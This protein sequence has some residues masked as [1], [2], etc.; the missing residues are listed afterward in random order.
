MGRVEMKA[1]SQTRTTLLTRLWRTWACTALLLW[2]GWAAAQGF[3]LRDD[4]GVVHHFEQPAQRVVSLLPSLTEV[5][6]AL[7]A[8]DRL[9]GVDRFSDWPAAVAQL[10]RLGGIDDAQI[11][12]IATLKPD[13]VLAST[14]A[15][16]ID[17]LES[18]GFKV[19]RLKSDTHADV[20]RTLILVAQLLG[21]PQRGVQV[22]DRI[23][24]Q[25]A[26]A[27]QQV[28]PTLRG[29]S[30]YFEIGG[31]PF[32]AGS[33]SFIGQTLLRLG[34]HNIVPPELGP[35]PKLNPE[36]VVRARPQIVM[37]ASREQTLMASRPGW[38]NLPA[39]QQGQQC[40]FASAEYDLLIRP[41][42][43]LGEAAALLARCL[44]RIESR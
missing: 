40:G 14:S 35:F 36:F 6:A 7:G 44:Q 27:A 25:L 41:G 12:A 23:Q 26:Q 30:V 8:A 31:G 5:V 9:V 39:I 3:S 38:Q 10:P 24:G 19:L 15:R 11:E 1:V 20:Q 28:P 17:R 2:A 32:A 42:P 34:L 29:Q 4:R 22:W 43:R 33:G 18:L 21:V 16:A 37:G 13:V